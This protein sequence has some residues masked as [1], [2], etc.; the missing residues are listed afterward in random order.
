MKPTVYHIPVCP[1]SQRVEIQL[2]L[3]S[4]RQDVDFVVVDIT[5]PR[6]DGRSRP[7]PPRNKYEHAAND[8]ELGL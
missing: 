4:R 7:W 8:G 2:E 6:P 1:F 3:K 5:Q